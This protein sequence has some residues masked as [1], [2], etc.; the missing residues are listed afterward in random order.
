MA[1]K[2]GGAQAHEKTNTKYVKAD[3]WKDEALSGKRKQKLLRR[4]LLRR[5]HCVEKLLKLKIDQALTD[6]LKKAK[7]IVE[8]KGS[9][10]GKKLEEL[11]AGDKTGL[12]KARF[13][14]SLEALERQGKGGHA[15]NGMRYDHV[16]LQVWMEMF[17]ASPKAL[18]V[19]R[20]SQLC[21]VPCDKTLAAYLRSC[22]ATNGFTRE[23]YE[24]MEDNKEQFDKFNEWWEEAHGYQLEGDGVLVFDEMVIKANL[25]YNSKSE[26][27]GGWVV[28]GG[29]FCTLD[30]IYEDIQR[31]SPA[32]AKY[33]MVSYWRSCESNFDLV[34]P[35]MVSEK[36]LDAPWI[37][38]Y[39]WDTVELFSQVGLHV[40]MCQCDGAAY[41]MRFVKMCCEFEYD[42]DGHDIAECDPGCNNPLTDRWMCFRFDGPHGLK[43][44]RNAAYSSRLSNK[45]RHF[46]IS[47]STV[48]SRFEALKRYMPKRMQRNMAAKDETELE[49]AASE[50]D[51]AITEAFFRAEHKI[52]E[53][54]ALPPALLQRSQDSF[55]A[56]LERKKKKRVERG[57]EKVRQAG[58]DTF[59]VPFG[60]AP[61]PTPLAS[62]DSPDHVVS[63][64]WYLLFDLLRWETAPGTRWGSS[65]FRPTRR[66]LNVRTLILTSFS[67]MTV[68]L[69][70]AITH[71]VVVITMILYIEE[72]ENQL[73]PRPI[74][75]ATDQAVTSWVARRDKIIGCMAMAL[76]LQSLRHIYVDF[77]M[78]RYGV[79]SEF[80]EPVLALLRGFEFFQAWRDDWSQMV[81]PSKS[82]R[83]KAFL[84]YMTWRNMKVSFLN[85]IK[86]IR[87][88]FM[89]HPNMPI[90][91]RRWSQSILESLFGE[92]RSYSRGTACTL[93][94]QLL[95]RM[96]T[97]YFKRYAALCKRI[98]YIPKK[99]DRNVLR[100]AKPKW[101]LDKAFKP[102]RDAGRLLFANSHAA[103]R[104]AGAVIPAAASLPHAPSSSGQHPPAADNTPAGPQPGVAVL[105]S[106]PVYP[107]RPGT[108]R[109]LVFNTLGRVFAK[110][111]P[112]GSCWIYAFLAHF[113][114]C[115]HLCP[116]DMQRIG[117]SEATARDV[118]WA[119]VLRKYVHHWVLAHK[120]QLQLDAADISVIPDILR[121][122][123]DEVGRLGGF[124][125]AHHLMALCVL[126]EVD[127]II[128]CKHELDNCD[129]RDRILR[130]QEPFRRAPNNGP[131]TVSPAEAELHCI[132]LDRRVV[133]VLYS[134]GHYDTLDPPDFFTAP[135]TA[136]NRAPSR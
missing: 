2:N 6:K 38:E 110:V 84:S 46:R 126:F 48:H 65:P 71:P 133:H 75:E 111:K 113:G 90:W 44:G 119:C 70:C 32:T 62:A 3:A 25:A 135:Q 94:S 98:N 130:W 81:F 95:E 99:T 35:V 106:A 60:P 51:A 69:A 132:A 34:G 85:A 73:G 82:V 77:E 5:D 42:K 131:V 45:P 61:A 13:D 23:A 76:Y 12:L 134:G 96:G 103:A 116:G 127:C 108:F 17:V 118:A 15:K 41:N 20:D 1:Q 83:N 29:Q 33:V 49:L 112:D 10:T 124:G 88:R 92:I 74:G 14:A 57:R 121:G 54:Q 101:D 100:R 39:F 114:L 16:S 97:V 122:P 128:H 87:L 93:M 66:Y 91:A 80:D 19:L 47:A 102:A 22:A 86:F 125:D 40:V 11:L 64:G 115:E 79:R 120:V 129:N 58:M 43:S 37:Y 50:A 136:L 123:G 55:I 26:L 105:P 31:G 52:P 72:Q 36:G 63:F 59:E 107:A 27:L 18:S 89:T 78:A 24:R 4:K 28:S 67:K 8:A 9:E 104:R 56:A 7:Q 68:G 21:G 117:D 53:G 30:R 109:F